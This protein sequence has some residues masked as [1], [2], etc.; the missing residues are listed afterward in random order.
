MFISRLIQVAFRN[1]NGD[2]S[3]S[4]SID[5]SDALSHV[6]RASPAQYLNPVQEL[7]NP[8]LGNGHELGLL[9]HSLETSRQGSSLDMDER[10]EFLRRNGDLSNEPV[11][12]SPPMSKRLKT[13]LSPEETNSR[14]YVEV[15]P[16][17]TQV[18]SASDASGGVVSR[19]SQS[20]S[21][22]NQLYA[23]AAFDPVTPTNG[24]QS[25][26]DNKTT[27]HFSFPP[28]TVSSTEDASQ[29]SQ[30]LKLTTLQVINSSQA[31][32]YK[33]K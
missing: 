1:G 32:L 12:L 22:S 10:T 8:I 29:G 27:R 25:N 15:V 3:R 31:W 2:C 4:G 26:I 11:K 23:T 6:Q 9:E 7:C 33:T 20:A 30:S 18:F 14:M 16:K 21:Q 24:L 28:P 13:I 17:V 19:P 5:S